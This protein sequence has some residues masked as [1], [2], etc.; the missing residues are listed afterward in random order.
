MTSRNN[1]IPTCHEYLAKVTR[2]SFPPKKEVE[3]L[4]RETKWGGG[5]GG[6]VLQCVC[7]GTTVGGGGVQTDLCVHIL[8]C[9]C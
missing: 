8:D 1:C 2:R 5:G 9:H 7:E 4:A 6:G 3:R